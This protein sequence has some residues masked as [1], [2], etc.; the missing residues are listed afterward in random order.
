MAT[1]ATD[2]DIIRMGIIDRIRTMAT[3]E[4][5]HSTGLEAIDITGTI[6]TIITIG[7][8]VE[9]G[10]KS[11]ELACHTSQLFFFARTVVLIGRNAAIDPLAVIRL[12]QIWAIP[13]V[14]L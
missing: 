8:K 7:T 10:L 5:L 3:M 11:T 2:T 14:S 6:V 1:R 9:Q 12:C 13:W 4:D